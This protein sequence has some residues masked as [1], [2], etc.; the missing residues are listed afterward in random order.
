MGEGGLS[1][2]LITVGQWAFNVSQYPALNNVVIL[3]NYYW[4]SVT[5][6]VS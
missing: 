4:V 6:R 5:K 1:I 3:L 2:D